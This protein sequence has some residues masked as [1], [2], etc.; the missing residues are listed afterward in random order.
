MPRNGSLSSAIVLDTFR[1]I[2]EA[3]DDFVVKNKLDIHCDD[4]LPRSDELAIAIFCN[5]FEELGYPN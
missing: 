2:K 5:A 3:T 4:F 1:S